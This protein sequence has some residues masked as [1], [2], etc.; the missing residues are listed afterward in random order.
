MV[1]L[2]PQRMNEYE[3]LTAKEQGFNIATVVDMG[4]LVNSSCRYEELAT[5][6]CFSGLC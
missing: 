4:N 3:A 2:R 6:A 1:Q 5:F